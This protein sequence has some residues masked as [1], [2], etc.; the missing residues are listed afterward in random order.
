MGFQVAFSLVLLL[1][2]LFGRFVF[3][4]GVAFDIEVFAQYEGLGGE[5]DAHQDELAVAFEV[6]K[7][8]FGLLGGV[9]VVE[10]EPV[11]QGSEQEEEGGPGVGEALPALRAE[12]EYVFGHGLHQGFAD[13]GAHGQGEGEAEV[14]DGGFP[15]QVEVVAQE[16]GG[17]AEEDGEHEH[18]P[19]L[20]GEP[21][22]L[23][24]EVD[25]V[26]NQGGGQYGG[27]AGQEAELLGGDEK[28]EEGE[29]V[30]QGG[31]VT[32]FSKYSGGRWR[33]VRLM[34]G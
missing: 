18:H 5:E 14:D 13:E 28:G 27:S 24:H 3:A 29:E 32:A 4:R 30:E 20:F 17:A 7:Q 16:D 19:L 6:D 33:C 15:A 31:H 9:V 2:W 12:A 23:P 1:A 26:H 22:L 21:P 8:V 34:C 25:A 11:V 10:A